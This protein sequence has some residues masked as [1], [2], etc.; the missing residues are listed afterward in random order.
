MTTAVNRSLQFRP[1]SFS[2]KSRPEQENK[3]IPEPLTRRGRDRHP[4]ARA[5]LSPS[6]SAAMRSICLPRCERCTNAWSSPSMSA[7]PSSRKA[8]LILRPTNGSPPAATISAPDADQND[9]IPG[10]GGSDRPLVSQSGSST[11]SQPPG[12]N[13]STMRRKGVPPVGHVREHRSCMNQIER[14]CMVEVFGTDVVPTHLDVVATDSIKPSACRYRSRVRGRRG[15]HDRRA[16]PQRSQSQ[17]RLR[18]IASPEQ[19]RD[20]AAVSGSVDL[21]RMPSD[22]GAHTL[23]NQPGKSNTPT[24]R[25]SR[26]ASDQRQAHNAWSARRY[27]NDSVATEHPALRIG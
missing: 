5:F 17:H 22:P 9:S 23:R 16:R 1:R 24:P 15:E 14:T 3:K 11:Q 2:P 20:P 13:A 18:H 25:P 27:P 6:A 12:R 4:P 8:S 19:H 21:A 7:R 10:V 26:R